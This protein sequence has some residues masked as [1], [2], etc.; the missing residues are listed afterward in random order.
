MIGKRLTLHFSGIS[1]IQTLRI[2]SLNEKPIEKQVSMVL[3]L[4]TLL[5]EFCLLV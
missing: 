3:S 1:S 4:S 5:P 2:H